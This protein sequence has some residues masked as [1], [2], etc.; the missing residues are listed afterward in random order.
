MKI[1][2][3]LAGFTIFFLSMFFCRTMKHPKV[4]SVSNSQINYTIGEMSTNINI[5]RSSL[6]LYENSISTKNIAIKAIEMPIGNDFERYVNYH[7]SK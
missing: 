5:R 3:S 1:A 7:Q 2:E 6:S 4:K